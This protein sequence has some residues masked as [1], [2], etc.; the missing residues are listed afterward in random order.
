MHKS[1]ER[2]LLPWPDLSWFIPEYSSHGRTFPGAGVFSDNTERHQSPVNREVFHMMDSEWNPSHLGHSQPWRIENYLGN[3]VLGTF[4]WLASDYS[5]P[6]SG[7]NTR[8]TCVRKDNPKGKWL[9]HTLVGS[10]QPPQGFGL[11]L[12]G[13]LSW[14]R[15]NQWKCL[16]CYYLESPRYTLPHWES[17][18]RSFW[19]SVHLCFWPLI[20]SHGHRL[21]SKPQAKSA[22]IRTQRVRERYSVSI[23]YVVGVIDN[24]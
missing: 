23:R 1:G 5:F 21:Q 11:S 18:R 19:S 22:E 17:Y 3:P 10:C 15:S 14:A 20:D 13:Q 4:V 7:F 12:P 24:K 8:R 2:S 16:L 6:F 9:Y